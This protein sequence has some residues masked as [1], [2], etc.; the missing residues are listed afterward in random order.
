MIMTQ[1]KKRRFIA[2][3][4]CPKCQATDTI[5][6]YFENNV[7]KLACTQCDYTESQADLNVTKKSREKESIIGVFKPE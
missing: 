2:G 4:T 3:A 6:L 7:E 5:M 1:R